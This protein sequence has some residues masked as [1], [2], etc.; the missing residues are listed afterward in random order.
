[1]TQYN[2]LSIKL[3]NSELNKLKFVI[4]NVTEV[5]LKLSSNVVRDSNDLNNSSYKW[6]LTN[7]Q[8]LI[9]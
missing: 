7:T 9:S 3:S 1:M 8:L 6:L 2:I 5:T 4:K